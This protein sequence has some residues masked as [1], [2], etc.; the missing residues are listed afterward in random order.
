[1][2]LK[3][4]ELI[5]LKKK[6]TNEK[7]DFLVD[8]TYDIQENQQSFGEFCQSCSFKVQEQIKEIDEA[9]YGSHDEPQKGLVPRVD[10]VE[11]SRAFWTRLMWVVLGSGTGF[12]VAYVIKIIIGT[13]TT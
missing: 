12:L 5:D 10:S 2:P 3:R 8:I 1:M 11:K 13:V 4:T 9:I 7:I 6:S